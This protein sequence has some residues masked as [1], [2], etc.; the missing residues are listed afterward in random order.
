MMLHSRMRR[1]SAFATRNTLFYPW[2]AELSTGTTHIFVSAAEQVRQDCLLL[3]Q[4]NGLVVFL[5]CAR[6]PQPRLAWLSCCTKRCRRAFPAGQKHSKPW[7]ADSKC[8]LI[9]GSP[10]VFRVVSLVARL[11]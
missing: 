10:P 6:A 8:C 9:Q 4:H 3:R 2:P 11:W 7:Q 5:P 1:A